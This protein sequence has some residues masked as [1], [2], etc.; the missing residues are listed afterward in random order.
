VVTEARDGA[1][2]PLRRPAHRRVLD[3]LGLA[4]RAGALIT[5]I[6]S[7]RRAARDDK[8]FRVI[9]ADDAA[10]GQQGKLTPLLDARKVPY[11]TLFTRFE[12]GAALG[13][14]SVSAVGITDRSFA[15]RTGELVAA[16]SEDRF[17]A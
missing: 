8:V 14:D 10:P 11:H 16:L 5:G 7:V 13:R 12:L 17:T 15:R 2:A 9:L 1:E 6:D 4:A 3:L